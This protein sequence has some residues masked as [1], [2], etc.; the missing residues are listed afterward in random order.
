MSSSNNS[1]AIERVA[2]L[3]WVGS[4]GAATA[5]ALAH[6]ERTKVGSAR[7]RLAAA[8]RDRLLS[9]Q[10][11]LVAQPALYTLTPAGLRASCLA[12]LP[13]CRVSA[14]NALHLIVCAA[15]AAGLE[16]CYPDHRVI[17][18]RDLRRQERERGAP[19]ASARLGGAHGEPPLHRPDLVLLPTALEPGLPV[20]VEVELA[21]KAP[22]RLAGICRSWAR[23]K[24]VA[25]VLYV[26]APSAERALVRAI[27]HVDAGSRVVVVPLDALAGVLAHAME[28]TEIRL[29]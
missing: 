7:A 26:A 1:P 13:P 6:R 21:V 8:A 23:C 12:G 2:M 19:F 24:D 27:A 4:L 16:R 25:G 10:R 28:G 15:V 20:A 17:G 14:A 5:E 22:Q 9:R 18:E 11:P 29:G 3:Q